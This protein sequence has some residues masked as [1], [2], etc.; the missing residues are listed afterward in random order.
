MHF[1]GNR[2]FIDGEEY[3]NRDHRGMHVSSSAIGQKIHSDG[4]KEMTSIDMDIAQY[5]KQRKLLRIIEHKNVGE[6]IGFQ[7][8]Q[9]LNVLDKCIKLGVRF[10]LLAEGSGCFIIFATAE[11]LK[12]G[13]RK[14]EVTSRYVITDINDNK[15]LETGDWDEVCTWMNG[16]SDWTPRNRAPRK[17][18]AA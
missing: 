9:L 7:Q 3:I 13:R 5:K 2:V 8:R 18:W 14:C 10:K 6:N 16:G 12:E 17:E 15:V 4:P 11:G 1:I